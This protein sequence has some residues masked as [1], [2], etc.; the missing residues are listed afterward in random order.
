MGRTECSNDPKAPKANTLIPAGSLL[1]V[2]DNGAVLQGRA[3]PRTTENP[4]SR[5]P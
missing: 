2:N 3:A 5:A 1:V 4:S